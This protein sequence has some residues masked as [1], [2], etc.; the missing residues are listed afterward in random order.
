MKEGFY[1]KRLKRYLDL[2][3]K[4]QIKIYIFEEFKKNP[5]K[6]V[7]DLYGF[8]DVDTGF[9]PDTS[10]RHNPGAIPKV[11]LLNRLFYNPTLINMA[12]SVVPEGL[13]LK[14]KQIQ[15]LNLSS[16]PKLPADLR[17]KL[18]NF[19]REDIFKLEGLLERDLS[20]WLNAT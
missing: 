2:F 6:T 8:L 14:L 13:H 1:Y 20:I 11:R 9:A 16:A 15:Q 18:L 19:Y 5:A 12:K 10:V 3:P 7:V 17:S 4:D